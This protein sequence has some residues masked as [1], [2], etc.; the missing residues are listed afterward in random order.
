M[1]KV[2]LFVRRGSYTGIVLGFI[3]CT[4]L[5]SNTAGAVFLSPY[6]NASKRPVC[7]STPI[8]SVETSQK[9]VALTFDDGPWP[10]NTQ[11]VMNHLEAYNAK[12]TFFMV[13]NN[14]LQYSAIAQ[15]V[16]RRGHEVAGHA[17]THAYYTDSKIAAEIAPSGRDI[18]DVIGQGVQIWAFRPPGLTQGPNIDKTVAA[19]GLCNIHTDYDIGDWKSPRISSATI[20]DRFKRSLHPGYISLLHDG[21]SH[22]QTVNAMPCILSYAQSQGYQFVT[23][24]QLLNMRNQSN[25]GTPSPYSSGQLPPKPTGFVIKSVS[26][27]QV[28]MGWNAVNGAIH[29]HV[30]WSTDNF[31]TLSGE[32]ITQNTSQSVPFNGKD[33]WVR[34]AAFAGQ[35]DGEYALAFI[36]K[37]L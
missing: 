16:Y 21:G 3:S 24:S 23:V 7:S 1:E 37:P 26:T 5:A 33:V 15:D 12:G 35:G 25:S 13:S 29:Y 8:R 19:Y 10:V 20:C 31:K 36:K 6:L 11:S 30:Q 34:V 2:K 32:L 18:Y 27:S 4:L 22:T 28:V 14:V 9:V 17:K